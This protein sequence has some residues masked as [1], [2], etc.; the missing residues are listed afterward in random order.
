[1]KA[2]GMSK[3]N[4]IRF[5]VLLH[6]LSQEALHTLCERYRIPIDFRELALLVVK[7]LSLYK[8]AS[9]LSSEEVL[10]LL[11]KIDA[12]RREDRFILFLEVASIIFGE[13]PGRRIISCYEAAK[14]ISIQ[15]I[16]ESSTGKEIAE[17]IR[18]RRLEAI[19]QRIV[20]KE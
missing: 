2:T 18:K 15:D 14:N 16:L 13:E 6:G 4:K 17:K 8:K 19:H 20:Q 12:F 11:E 5:A 9:L 3:D 10:A 1:M 7:Y